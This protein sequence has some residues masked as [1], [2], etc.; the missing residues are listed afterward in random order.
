MQTEKHKVLPV[1]LVVLK[2]N[3]EQALGN[4]QGRELQVDGEKG[5][6]RSS[7]LDRFLLYIK[8][9]ELHAKVINAF[10]K[11]PRQ[12]WVSPSS[13]KHHPL[14]ERDI[15]GLV[16][17]TNRVCAVALTLLDAYNIEPG[18]EEFDHV[19]AA[20]LLHDI[21]K[22]CSKENNPHLGEGKKP[23]WNPDWKLADDHNKMIAD[24]LWDLKFPEQVCRAVL[25]HHGKWG[26]PPADITNHAIIPLIVHLADKIASNQDL[27]LLCGW[28]PATYLSK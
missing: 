20:C 14:D 27:T 3:L 23:I 13:V 22:G 16:I 18:S 12:F 1:E 10:R 26:K 6:L 25:L 7:G 21:L 15:K 11:A 19:M 9:A 2:R 5:I 24:F 8:N 17:H 4:D 28:D